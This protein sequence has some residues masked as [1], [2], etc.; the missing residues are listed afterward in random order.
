MFHCTGKAHRRPN[1]PEGLVFFSPPRLFKKVF[2]KHPNF[3]LE[4]TV[5]NVP[6]DSMNAPACAMDE[7]VKSND[8]HAGT[9]LFP[10]SNLMLQIGSVTTMVLP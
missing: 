1:A 2:G 7:I 10:M 5:A 4:V 3:K 6:N 9:S 8:T